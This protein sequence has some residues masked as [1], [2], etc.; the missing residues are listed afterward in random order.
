MDSTHPF[1]IPNTPYM[2]KKVCPSLGSQGVPKNLKYFFL[3]PKNIS[4]KVFK[5]K[6]EKCFTKNC[7]GC[8]KSTL[9]ACKQNF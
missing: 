4:G 1:L 2:Q 3:Y 7:T 9:R 6:S 8:P 5:K